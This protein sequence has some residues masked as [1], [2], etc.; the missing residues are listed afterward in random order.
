[1]SHLLS[2]SCRVLHV[3][4][5]LSH[6]CT[7]GLNSEHSLLH[8]NITNRLNTFRE[9]SWNSALKMPSAYVMYDPGLKVV[10]VAHSFCVHGCKCVNHPC[11]ELNQLLSSIKLHLFPC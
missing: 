3:N 5:H 10:G 2:V 7:D 6:S 1:M 8:H 4:Q 11:S 9:E